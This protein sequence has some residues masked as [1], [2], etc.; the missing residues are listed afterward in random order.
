MAAP[1]ILGVDP[2]LNTTGYAVIEVHAD[3][4]KRKSRLG[5]KSVRGF[6]SHHLP[7]MTLQTR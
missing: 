6:P 3:G 1:R 4:P 7:R 5:T 2:G